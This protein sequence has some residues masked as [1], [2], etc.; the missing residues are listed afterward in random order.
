MAFA[1][2]EFV[3]EV[4]KVFY[5]PSDPEAQVH[6]FSHAHRDLVLKRLEHGLAEGSG[7]SR[8]S[9]ATALPLLEEFPH[10]ADLC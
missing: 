2:E 3:V 6:F 8:R 1:S 7:L 10:A 4:G 9:E 5:K